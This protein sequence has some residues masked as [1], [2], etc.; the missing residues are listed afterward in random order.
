MPKPA[1]S[2][3]ILAAQLVEPLRGS[4]RLHGRLLSA[5][6]AEFPR[7]WCPAIPT[8]SGLCRGRGDRQVGFRLLRHH[9]GP[10]DHVERPCCPLQS[11]QELPEDRRFSL[12]N[13]YR[14]VCHFIGSDAS[15][16][17]ATDTCQYA[18]ADGSQLQL[19]QL[20]PAAMW[21]SRP[22]RHMPYQDHEIDRSLT[23][24]NASCSE[25]S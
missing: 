14:L 19:F 9:S 3:H 21:P 13:D 4:P 11:T 12:G 17:S 2:C 20:A 5:F 1:A 24:V 6:R 15:G 8:H 23:V 16:P 10:S 18:R 25:G 7:R 22:V